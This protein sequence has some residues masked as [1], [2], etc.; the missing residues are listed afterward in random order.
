LKLAII[1]PACTFYGIYVYQRDRGL[2]L[3]FLERLT[4]QTLFAHLSSTKT[5]S[6]SDS[7]ILVNVTSNQV[8]YLNS[9][10]QELFLA[11]DAKAIV[12]TVTGVVRGEYSLR[13]VEKLASIFIEVGKVQ[14]SEAR[15]AESQPLLMGLYE[16]M[17]MRV[18]GLET[19]SVK[20]RV[21]DEEA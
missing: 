2:R 19:M 11:S 20:V 13:I 7:L 3:S 5:N 18:S 4:T 9:Q 6:G 1:L 21:V 17:R 14:S 12:R 15:G 16:R 10:A 8:E